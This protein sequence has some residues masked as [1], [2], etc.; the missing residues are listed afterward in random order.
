MCMSVTVTVTK[1]MSLV[2]KCGGFFRGPI[3]LIVIWISRD[4]VLRKRPHASPKP[5]LAA[6]VRM[7]VWKYACSC[8][9]FA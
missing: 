9:N 6:H 5:V 1:G 3:L 7:H 4:F 2:G 8:I